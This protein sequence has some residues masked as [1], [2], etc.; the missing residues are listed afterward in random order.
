[1]KEYRIVVYREGLLGSVLLGAS[2]V[3]PEKFANFLNSHAAQ[4]WE[5]KTMER[6]IR[7]SLLIFKREAF[8][9]I[10]EREKTAVAAQPAAP[11]PAAS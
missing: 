2:K 6:E 11:A 5:V 4:G 1:M 7:R 8:I 10:L 9:V 3:D